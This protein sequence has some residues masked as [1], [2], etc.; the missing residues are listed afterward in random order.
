MAVIVQWRR[1][2]AD[3][4]RQWTPS[5]ATAVHSASL[6]GAHRQLIHSLSCST[7]SWHPGPSLLSDLLASESFP[8]APPERPADNQQARRYLLFFD[9]GSRGNPGPGGA[10]AVI[11]SVDEQHSTPSLVWS[12]AMSYANPATTNNL[13]EYWGVVTGLQAAQSNDYRPIEVIGDS[14]LILGQLRRSRPPRNSKLLPLY[15]TARRLADQL[16][17][18]HWHHHLRAYNKMADHAANTAMD[19]LA[20]TQ[21]FHS[22]H[23]PA[24]LHLQTLL[25]GDF[26]HWQEAASARQ[27]PTW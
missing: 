13:A 15:A 6:R 18:H 26:Q 12:A 20:S 16:N 22:T 7:P 21:T 8:P 5:A 2:M 10:G 1:G 23:R 3:S 17:V 4:T 27:E 14:A 19:Q 11:L 25:P 24:H 9:G